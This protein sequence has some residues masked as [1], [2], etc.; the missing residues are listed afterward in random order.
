MEGVA[1]N[2]SA[3]LDDRYGRGQYG[4]VSD[5]SDAPLEDA[6]ALLA[7]ERLT[8]LAPPDAATRRLRCCMHAS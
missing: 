3:M 6:V 5:K 4:E 1:A 7:R 2:L 8:G